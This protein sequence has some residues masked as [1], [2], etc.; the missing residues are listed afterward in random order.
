MQFGALELGERAASGASA[1]QRAPR[2][3]G[4]LAQAPV[5]P[6]SRDRGIT[7]DL[8]GGHF[9]IMQAAARAPDDAAFPAKGDKSARTAAQP[10]GQR[11]KAADAFYL[12][13]ELEGD[14]VNPLRSPVWS[15]AFWAD[16]LRLAGD[17][18]LRAI[19]GYGVRPWRMLAWLAVPYLVATGVFLLAGM[20]MPPPSDEVTIPYPCD[21]RAPLQDAAALSAATYVSF[22]PAFVTQWRVSSCPVAG[23][24]VT[25]SELA[26]TERAL[27][28]FL[29]PLALLTF[30]GVLRRLLGYR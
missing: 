25:A 1:P 19:T 17:R 30:S 24:P 12:R 27:G 7:L 9:V 16:V 21:A 22:D 18:L 13:R 29:I 8:R 14:R 3:N 4:E 28:W 6:R 20:T 11:R 15:A 5:A 10:R 2:S 26:K 23:T